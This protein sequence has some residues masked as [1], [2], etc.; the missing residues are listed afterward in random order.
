MQLKVNVMTSMPGDVRVHLETGE[1]ARGAR[2]TER[3]LAERIEQ[4]IRTLR[5][6]TAVVECKQA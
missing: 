3:E 6:R 2:S 1:T 4:G 5:S